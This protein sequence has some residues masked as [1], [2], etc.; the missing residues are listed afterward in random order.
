MLRTIEG[1]DEFGDGTVPRFSAR[2]KGLPGTSAAISGRAERHG[3]L[4]SNAAVLDQIYTALTGTD[5]DYMDD[6]AGAADLGLSLPELV[7]AGDEIEVTVE[8]SEDA[9]LLEATVLDEAGRRVAGE[10]LRREAP[11]VFRAFI[12]PL[13]PGGYRVVAAP[14]DFT[15]NPAKPVTGA[16]LV[17]DPTEPLDD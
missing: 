17:W 2:P 14:K 5:I 8:A 16:L 1:K 15:A 9:L 13:P 11:R 12:E 10:I 4:Q 7:P 3:S 6:D